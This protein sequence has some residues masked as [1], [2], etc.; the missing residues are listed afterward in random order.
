MYKVGTINAKELACDLI[1][2]G[3]NAYTVIYGDYGGVGRQIMDKLITADNGQWY[4]EELRN[5][6]QIYNV[7]N[8]RL[9]KDQ[10]ASAFTDKRLP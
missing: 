3:M 1:E 2:C 8:Y 4:E 9:A 10:A 6:F 7:V 5:G